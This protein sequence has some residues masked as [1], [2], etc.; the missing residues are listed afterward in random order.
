MAPPAW[1]LGSGRGRMGWGLLVS[2]PLEG[3]PFVLL[4]FF[5]SLLF[6]AWWCERFGIEAVADVSLC[7]SKL[8]VCAAQEAVDGRTRGLVR[9]EVCEKTAL[10]VCQIV[11]DF[12]R[13]AVG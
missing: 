10:S 4:F 5:F 3:C 2:F 12:W 13:E 1:A 8:C 7:R 11:G 6:Q 9:I